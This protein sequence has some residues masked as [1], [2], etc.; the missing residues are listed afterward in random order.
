MRLSP[1]DPMTC[2]QGH[3]YTAEQ[4]AADHGAMDQFA[5]T[6]GKNVTLDKCLAGFSF[7]RNPEVVPPGKLPTTPS[8]T[9][10]T[11]TR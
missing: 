8:W 7:S 4:N 11:G 2:D 9:T 1:S 3:G 10:T 5:Q 6:T